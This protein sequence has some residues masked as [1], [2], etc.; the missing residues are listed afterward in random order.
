MSENY[1]IDFVIPWVDGSDPEWLAEKA[2]YDPIVTDDKEVNSTNRYRDWGLMKYWFRGVEKF[3]PWVRKIHFITWGHVPEFLD[4]N[5]PK[6]HIVN[7]KDFIPEDC[8]PT[9]N[10]CAIETALNQIPDLKEHFV[11]FND[12]MFLLKPVSKDVF[13]RNGLPCGYFEDNPS[14][15]YGNSD[16]GHWIFNALCLVNKH[17]N[18][19]RQMK[20]NLKKWFSQPLLSKSFFYTLLSSPWNNVLGIPASH[21]P[22][23][24]LKSTWE[25]VWHAEYDFLNET[26]HA[27]FRRANSIEQDLFRYW[28]FMEGSFYP[29]QENGMYLSLQFN[30]IDEIVSIIKKS[31]YSYVCLNDCCSENFEVCKKYLDG[32]FSYILGE[33]S[34]FEKRI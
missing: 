22:A 14:Y 6:V 9:Y 30:R 26:M 32:A 12:D 15:V 27:K 1:D 4:V 19:H 13:F 11:Y 20:K 3:A 23:A 2:K 29:R 16:Y 8:L 31:E 10:S 21:M 33:E 24:F 5:H 7:H 34:G 28:Q 17:F 18:K 25:K